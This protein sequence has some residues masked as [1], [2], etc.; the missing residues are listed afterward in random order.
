MSY[1]Y[2][3]LLKT[4]LDPVQTECCCSEGNTVVAAGA[5][6][7]K[8]QVLAT[9]FAWLV[10]SKEIPASKIL[11][12]TFTKKAAG[13]M[14]ERIYETLSFFAAN[15]ETPEKEKSLAEN[16]L[17]EFSEAKIKTLDSYCSGI[18]KQAASMYGIRPDFSTGSED[19]ESDI[20]ELALPFVFKNKERLCIRSFA[21]PG[22]F[23][24]FSDKIL[25]EAII[26]HTSIAGESGLF[27]K[28]LVLQ[29]TLIVKAYNYFILGDEQQD[30][31]AFKN[32]KKYLYEVLTAKTGTACYT[33][34]KLIGEIQNV[35]DEELESSTKE[36]KFLSLLKQNKETLFELFDKVIN[37]NKINDSTE[38]YKEQII[39]CQTNLNKISSLVSKITYNA[40]GDFVSKEYLKF[41]KEPFIPLLSSIIQFFEDYEALK[42][43]AEL[44]DE[45]TALVNDAKRESGNLTFND[46]SELAFKILNEDE[47]IRKQ[48]QEAYDII[49]IDEFQDNNGKN[50][51]L[52]FNLCGDKEKLFFVGDEKQSIYKFRGADV[53]V[54]NSLKNDKRIRP[55]KS[56]T[57]NYRSSHQMLAAFNL[58]FN[59]E[60]YAFFD[61]NTQEDYE[62]TYTLRALKYDSETKQEKPEAV[63]NAANV[64]VH[65]CML[66]T[67]KLIESGEDESLD[68]K[69]QKAYFIVSKISELK[70]KNQSLSYS[71]F[72]I[73]DKGRTDRGTLIKWLN[74]FNI[75]YIIDSN[76]SLFADG[77]VNDIY[78][79]LRLCVYPSDKKAYAGYLSSPFK[80]YD[81][82]SVINMVSDFTKEEIPGKDKVLSQPI[83]KTL[84]EL[85]INSGYYYET[86]Q[87]LSTSIFS[88]QFDLLFELGRQCDERGKSVSWFIDQ[89]AVIKDNE[90]TSFRDNTDLDVK[91]ISY[92]LEKSDGVNIMTIHK[93]KGLQFKHVF[94]YGIT[95]ITKRENDTSFF[96]DEETG[97]SLIT[98]GRSSNFFYLINKTIERKKELAEF[99]RL[100]YVAVTRAIDSVYITGSW[101]VKLDS[102]N[103]KM[104]TKKYSTSPEPGTTDFNLIER[105]AYA[106]YSLIVDDLNLVMT[107]PVYT[108]GAP[109]DFYSFPPVSK[110]EAYSH[111]KESDKNALEE[112]YKNYQTEAVIKLPEITSNRKTPSSLET[113]RTQPAEDSDSGEKFEKSEDYLYS[114]KFT[115]AD[116]GT[117][118]HA[119]LEAQANG[120]TPENYEVRTAMFKDLKE[121]EQEE[122]KEICKKMC[123]DFKAS[124]I[125]KRFEEAKAAG[126]FYKAEYAFRMFL[127]GSIFTGSID[128][129]FEN[130]D[131]TYTIVDYKSDTEIKPEIYEPQQACYKTAASKLLDVGEEKISCSLYYL[132]HNKEVKLFNK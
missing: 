65:L 17:K 112:I 9:R 34:K 99:R 47:E 98:E 96:Y 116:F 124:E 28:K 32:Y 114:E 66:N 38:Q 16:A 126:R 91:D 100:I 106:W 1:E 128:L 80:G 40:R 75:P 82:N 93:S 6:S 113:N 50:R 2:L 95:G 81:F 60:R 84:T 59:N 37:Q 13:E 130:P 22:K 45:F 67:S 5:G 56:M 85:W 97:P 110:K 125:G 108:P 8:T 94:I 118:V 71:D 26:K 83:T 74:Y 104:S 105:L 103:K 31:P 111:K 46:V 27:S 119:Y 68:E 3:N 115:A 129:I 10:M 29:K 131:S 51:D 42:D 41:L 24:D 61:N 63:L 20:K 30:D 127:D 21:E 72:A 35:C 88:E 109:F 102:S 57:C 39:T 53:S 52:L 87:N 90:N 77:P 70:E 15:P 78:N 76:S 89:L 54:F 92:P 55:A 123:E 43:F 58:F 79:Y 132:K 7:G 64:P 121:K 11:T 4:N 14:F 48:E 69:N 120:I 86:L 101:S 122:Q 36:N 33:L 49:M 44:T 19:S 25:S 107:E 117:L 62:A 23:Q 12:L 18:V 73:L